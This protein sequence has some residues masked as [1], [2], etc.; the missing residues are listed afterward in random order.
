M[1]TP[2]REPTNVTKRTRG[3]LGITAALALLALLVVAIVYPREDARDAVDTTG[4]PGPSHPQDVEESWQASP[5]DSL[6]APGFDAYPP[7]FK[8]PDATT[9]TGDAVTASLALGT[10]ATPFGGTVG[11]SFEGTDLASPMWDAEVSNLDEMLAAVENPVIRFGGLKGDRRVWWTSANEP[12]PS[13]AE[14]TVTPENLENVAALAEEVDAS[15][16]LVVSLARFD[17]D[18]AS[19]MASHA[20]EIFGDRLLA[21]TIGNE[22][23]GYYLEGEPDRSV[24]DQDWDT[25]SYQDAL[26]EYAAAIEAASPGTPISGPGAYDAS[27]WRAFADSSVANQQ[28]LSMHWYPL[29]N[30]SGPASS[31]A[32]PTL[33]DL[34]SP[35]LRANAES[36]VG[37]GAKTADERDLPLWIEETGPTSCSGGNETSRTHAQSLWT[38]DYVLTAAELG[39]ERIAFHSTLMACQ[40]GAPMSPICAT[41]PYGDPGT[42]VQGRTSYLALMQLSWIPDGNMLTPTVSGDGKVMVHGILGEDASLTLVVTDLRDPASGADAIPVSV[43]APSGLGADAPASWS[44]ASGSLLT[45]ESLA[46]KENSLTA[47]VPVEPKLAALE[48][49]ASQPLTIASQPGSTTMLVLEPNK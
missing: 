37:M 33:E 36:I 44:P 30:C 1:A 4:T 21:I 28:A 49:S 38:T 46:A 40:G 2:R 31:S 17:A 42:I 13:W 5:A 19:D 6:L 12:M 9:L 27:W 23:N 48:L 47:L 14:A 11:F 32:N 25:A 18:R 22:P 29:W 7:T 43:S 3:I 24:R 39:A 20:R 10:D 15:V 34:T 41:G 45:G 35:Q 26:E 8:L 16:T